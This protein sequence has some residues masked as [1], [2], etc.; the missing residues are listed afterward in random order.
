MFVLGDP[1][2]RSYE[3]SFSRKVSQSRYDY[4]GRFMFLKMKDDLDGLAQLSVESGESAKVGANCLMGR[5]NGYR[6]ASCIRPT[7]RPA[8]RQP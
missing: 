6:R 4:V 5:L 8:T 3:P 1:H 7:P 2:C